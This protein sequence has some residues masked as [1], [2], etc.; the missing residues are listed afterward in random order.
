LSNPGAFFSSTL[1]NLITGAAS[2]LN[3]TGAS[4]PA[5]PAGLDY[6]RRQFRNQVI[7]GYPIGISP[8]YMLGGTSM[9]TQMYQL[10]KQETFAVAG[11]SGSISWNLNDNEFQ[12]LY[13]PIISPYLNNTAL[14]DDNGNAISG[15]SNTMWYLFCDPGLPQGSALVIGFLDGRDQ[16]FFDQADTQFNVPGGMQFRAY[17]DW[18]V[19]M[20]VYQLA[21]QSAGA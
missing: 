3:Q 17:L 21:L 14:T 8:R 9:E 6:A 7:N 10:W 1:G 19:A 15:Q 2:A 18:G 5:T 4:T 16:P 11:V 20:N 12:G 13:R